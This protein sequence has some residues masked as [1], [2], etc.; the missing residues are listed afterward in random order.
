MLFVFNGLNYKNRTDVT[1]KNKDLLRYRFPW[2]QMIQK[3]VKKLAQ[4]GGIEY[5]RPKFFVRTIL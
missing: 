2:L 5:N 1:E 3:S 4:S